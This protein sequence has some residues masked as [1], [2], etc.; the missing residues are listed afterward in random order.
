[1]IAC[2]WLLHGL[3]LSSYQQ[4]VLSELAE[5]ILKSVEEKKAAEWTPSLGQNAE[6]VAPPPLPDIVT[7]ST[8]CAEMVGK[9][10]RSRHKASKLMQRFMKCNIAFLEAES[11]YACITVM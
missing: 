3:P 6:S 10:R 9:K 4:K 11:R 1:M 7:S 8:P 5:L 2:K